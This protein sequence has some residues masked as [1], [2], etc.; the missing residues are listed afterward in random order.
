MKPPWKPIV[1]ASQTN[2]EKHRMTLKIPHKLGY[3][4]SFCNSKDET[5]KSK[6]QQKRI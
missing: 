6:F 2:I 4:P 5:A 1:P 3:L